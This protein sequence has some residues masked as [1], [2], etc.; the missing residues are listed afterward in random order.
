MRPTETAIDHLR[1]LLS[2][3][4][5]PRCCKMRARG[6]TDNHSPDCPWAAAK[7]WLAEQDTCSPLPAD[8]SL[9]GCV[10]TEGPPLTDEERQL[11]PRGPYAV[12]VMV[13]DDTLG[14]IVRLTRD[15]T[16]VVACFARCVDELQGI[17][18]A[19]N[20]AQ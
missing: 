15:G 1:R 12:D 17:A 4:C 5:P 2:S 13:I 18:D 7:A 14:P 11:Q 10:I 6:T 9:T 16:E 20:A 8:L 3:P 19:L